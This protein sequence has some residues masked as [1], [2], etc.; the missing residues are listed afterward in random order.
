MK[1]STSFNA[2]E[3]LACLL[4]KIAPLETAPLEN[5]QTEMANDG[6]KETSQQISPTKD[7]PARGRTPIDRLDPSDRSPQLKSSGAG[8]KSGAKPAAKKSQLRGKGSHG[9]R[10]KDSDGK[11]IK[12][13]YKRKIKTEGDTL[14]LK[15]PRIHEDDS[16]NADGKHSAPGPMRPCLFL[17]VVPCQNTCAQFAKNAVY[18]WQTVTEWD[19]T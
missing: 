19:K 11:P 18:L 6:D 12:G 7:R 10:G 13:T 5:E 15:I 9:P 3:A 2:V 8:A 4:G 17:N 14:K 16:H 1:I